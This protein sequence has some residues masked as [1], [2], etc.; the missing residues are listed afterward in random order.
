MYQFI[1][2]LAN[3]LW[4]IVLVA[5]E[6]TEFR[7]LFIT[8]FFKNKCIYQ[9][10]NLL[11]NEK[12]HNFKKRKIL[13]IRTLLKELWNWFNGLGPGPVEIFFIL[14]RQYTNLFFL[15]IL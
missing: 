11:L 9:I 14:F 4:S 13:L 10:L 15:N 6:R 1:L 2:P 5:I 12:I 3:E 7:F 8:V